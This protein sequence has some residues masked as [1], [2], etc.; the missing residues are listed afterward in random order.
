[1]SDLLVDY[2]VF[3]AMSEPEQAHIKYALE[4]CDI[5]LEDVRCV[6]VDETT[7]EFV[8]AVIYE[9]LPGNAINVVDSEDGESFKIK[10]RVLGDEARVR[11]LCGEDEWVPKWA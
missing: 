3:A 5:D 9:R 1:M 10:V 4:S 8:G 11:E 6:V 7:G 2:L